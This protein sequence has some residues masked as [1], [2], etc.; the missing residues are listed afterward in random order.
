MLTSNIMF[1]SNV[2]LR[3]SVRK[4]GMKPYHIVKEFGTLIGGAQNAARV[5]GVTILLRYEKLIISFK[6]LLLLMILLLNSWMD[7]H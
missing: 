6:F 7:L 2:P 4:H 1:P 3:V 5:I